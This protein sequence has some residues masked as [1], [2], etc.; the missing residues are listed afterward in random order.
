MINER[1]RTKYEVKGWKQGWNEMRKKKDRQS[2]EQTGRQ[3]ETDRSD[4][5]IVCA[6]CGPKG[7]G[8]LIDRWIDR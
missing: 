2:D 4:R 3:M 6:P 5:R 8:R 7:K 1:S